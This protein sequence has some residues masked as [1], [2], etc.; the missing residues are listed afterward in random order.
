MPSNMIQNPDLVVNTIGGV[1]FF[2]AHADG[3][4]AVIDG[5]TTYGRVTYE[6]N[7]PFVAGE[8]YLLDIGISELS[9]GLDPQV[10]IVCAEG[11]PMNL[12]NGENRFTV[13]ADMDPNDYGFLV[14]KGSGAST[15]ARLS[16]PS[17]TE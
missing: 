13:R 12:V 16:T 10:Q 2:N 11:G 14:I 17:L 1:Q 3:A 8:T 9:G 5:G 4:D 7:S 15:T 6:L